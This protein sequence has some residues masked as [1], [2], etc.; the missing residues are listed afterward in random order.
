MKR[1]NKKLNK[2]N[3]V[4]LN[5]VK[6]NKRNL[7]KLRN[8]LVNTWGGLNSGKDRTGACSTYWW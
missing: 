2:R 8:S 6:P 4:M 5:K 3:K 7:L 1:T